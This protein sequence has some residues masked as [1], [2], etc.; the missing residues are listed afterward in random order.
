MTSLQ[1]RQ[2][3]MM[4]SPRHVLPPIASKS[5][6]RSPTHHL[7]ADASNH[8][9]NDHGGAALHGGHASEDEHELPRFA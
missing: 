7:T 6:A 4:L 9:T 5:P 8:V 3:T 2:R 1:V